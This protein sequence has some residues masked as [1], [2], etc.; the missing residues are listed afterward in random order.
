MATLC[1]RTMQTIWMDNA[2]D[3]DVGY[4]CGDIRDGDSSWL[5]WRLS[6][7]CLLYRGNEV[8]CDI[9]G[10]LTK[11]E[12]AAAKRYATC[13]RQP[14]HRSLLNPLTNDHLGCCVRFSTH[15]CIRIPIKNSFSFTNI[16]YAQQKKSP[17]G[18]KQIHFNHEENTEVILI[19]LHFH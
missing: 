7:A 19:V 8:Y 5:I 3:D 16:V 15:N 1:A 4:W 13:D 11:R 17:S 2:D 10:S 6:F 14:N 18:N 12:C 9:A